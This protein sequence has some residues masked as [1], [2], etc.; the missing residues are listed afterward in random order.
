MAARLM[1]ALLLIAGLA[2]CQPVLAIDFFFSPDTSY[3]ALGDTVSLSGQIGPSDTLRSFTIYI[4]NDTNRI[5]LAPPVMVG[6]LL[7]GHEGLQFNY[8]DHPPN[9]P[10]R[11]EIGG[12]IFGTDFW[13][14]P[15]ELFRLRFVLRAC[16][17][18]EPAADVGFRHPD[19]S[20][21]LGN[22]DPPTFLIC[23]RVPQSPAHLIIYVFPPGSVTLR[24]DGV[25]LDALGRPLLL[26]VSY[27]VYQ[28]QILPSALPVVN[29]ATVTDT[30][31]TDGFSTGVE[32]LYHVSAQTVP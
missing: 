28:Q 8:F 32:Y 12:A 4:Y 24:W 23:D 27:Q 30:F 14:G 31:Y 25:R 20:F 22:Y 26:P 16:V 2:F 15:G 1:C 29:I 21:V 7:A 10:T 17:D 5:D 13:A 18:Y 9:A 11:L 19:G 6:S 3:G